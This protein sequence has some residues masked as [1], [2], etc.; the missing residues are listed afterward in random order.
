MGGKERE[1]KV[2]EI[3]K[4][5]E[6]ISELQDTIKQEATRFRSQVAKDKSLRVKIIKDRTHHLM[7]DQDSQHRVSD[8]GFDIR[9]Y[10]R[11]DEAVWKYPQVRDW[12]NSYAP[13]QSQNETTV[14]YIDTG[15]TIEVDK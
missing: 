15:Y 2:R 3:R 1:K 12:F 6:K 8:R 10:S 5:E 4:M 14:K 11:M 13:A 7:K 9:S